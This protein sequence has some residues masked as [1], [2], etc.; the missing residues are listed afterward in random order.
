M[1]ALLAEGATDKESAKT[2]AELGL[3]ALGRRSLHGSLCGKL[4]LVANPLEA[5]IPSKKKRTAYKKPKLDMK[6]ARFYLP[7]D[8]EYEALDRFPK[9]SFAALVVGLI[10]LTAFFTALHFFLPSLVDVAVGYF[11]R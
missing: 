5:E 9:Q 8:R 3:S 6:A 1:R 7:K 10:L 4:F 2:A 11:T